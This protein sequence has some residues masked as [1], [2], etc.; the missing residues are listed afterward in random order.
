[1]KWGLDETRL[2]AKITKIEACAASFIGLEGF[3][4]GCEEGVWGV[5]SNNSLF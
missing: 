3:G 5:E 1:M 2:S 4:G